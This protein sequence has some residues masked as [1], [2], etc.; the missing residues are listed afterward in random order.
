[1]GH[2][3]VG[4]TFGLTTDETGMVG[5]KHYLADDSASVNTLIMEGVTFYAEDA[6]GIFKAPIAVE[7]ATE[8]ASLSTEE[9]TVATEAKK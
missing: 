7:A 6:S 5:M 9:A 3:S 4:E 1:M 8:P 2:G